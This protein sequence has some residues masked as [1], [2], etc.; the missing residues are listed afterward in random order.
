MGDHFHQKPC[1]TL[2][3]TFSMPVGKGWGVDQD[4]KSTQ[5]FWGGGVSMSGSQRPPGLGVVM[6]GL[7]DPYSV[8][9][10]SLFSEGTLEPP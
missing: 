4:D 5:G 10:L 8:Q 3:L 2:F 6:N 7:E 9:V 1:N